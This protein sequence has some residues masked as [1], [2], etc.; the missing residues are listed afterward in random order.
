MGEASYARTDRYQISWTE[1]V[2]NRID[3]K[4]LKQAEPQTYERY[5]KQVNSRRFSV[6]K[7]VA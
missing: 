6:K 2:Q 3:A 7:T 5:L 1:S 4:M